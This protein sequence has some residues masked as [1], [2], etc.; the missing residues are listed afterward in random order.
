[1]PSFVRS[2]LRDP[3][4]FSRI[5]ASLFAIVLSVGLFLPT[6]RAQDDANAA[7]ADKDSAAVAMYADAANFQTNG[8]I[9]LAI[10]TWQKFLK[11]FPESPLASKASHYLGVCYMQRDTPDLKAAAD[12][13]AVALKDKKYELREES[14]S[15]RG[16]CLYAATGSDDAADEKLLREAVDTYN[17]L[18]REFPDSRLLDRAYFYRG[19][20]QYSLGDLDAAVKSYDAMLQLDD[21]GDSPLRCD[22]LYAR[23]VAL[24]ELERFDQAQS[25]Y[26]QL[27]DACAGSELI[28]DV[29]IRMGDMDLLQGKLDSAIKQFAAVTSNTSATEDDRAYSFFR[30]G[31]AHAQNGS[32]G[33]ASKSYEALLSEYP[34]SPYA[35]AATLA[36]AQTL[37]QAGDLD[38][39]AKRFRDVLEGSDPEAA[40]ESAHWLARIELGKA[41]RD[42]AQA[43]EPAKTALKVASSRIE[44]GPQGKFAVALKLDAAEALSLLPERLDEAFERYRQ[45]SQEHADHPLAPRALYNAAFVALKL[46]KANDAIQL[47]NEFE[48]KHAND[49]LAPDASFVGAEALLA[50]SKPAEA[51]AQYQELINNTQHRNHPERSTWILRAATAWK[52]ADQPEKTISLVRENLDGLKS[53]DQKAEALMLAGQSELVLGKADEAAATFQQSREV[54]PEWSRSDEA[55]LM[56]GQSQLKA[57]KRDAAEG[58]WKELVRTAPETRAADQARYKLGQL[59]SGDKN[60]AQAIEYFQPVLDAKRDTALLPFARYAMGMAQLQ[61]QQY[62]SAAASLTDVI[63][64]SPDHSLMD[65]ALLARGIAR[66][67]LNE[68]AAARAD[69]QAYLNTEP[70]GNNLG[71]ALYELALLDQNASQT[72]TAAETLQRIVTEVPNYPDMDKVLYELGWSLRESGQEDQALQ[73][74]EE[75]IQRFPENELVADAAYFVGQN[76]YQNERWSEAAKAFQIAADKSNDLDAKEKSLYRL[77]WCFYKQGQY[78]DAEAAFK[79][80]YVEVQQG[81]LLLDSMMMIGESRFKQENFETA[82]RAYSKAREKIQADDDSAKTLRDAAERQ[83]R[84]LILLHGGQSAAQLSQFEDAIGWYDELRERF[85]ATAY[86]PQVFY[87]LGYAAQNVGDD[88]KALNFYSQVAD[89]YRN[90]IAARARFMMGEIHFA[91]KAFDKA[92]PEFQRVMFGFGAD[93]ADPVIKNWQAKS[94]F[95]AGRC[96]E[97]LMQSAQTSTAKAKAAQFAKDFYQYVIDQHPGHELAAKAKQRAEALKAS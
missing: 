4:G 27:L 86:L 34:E 94:G 46:G 5:V 74:F 38:A 32:P 87:E 84:E 6:V 64:E 12:A 23:G 95:E 19:E 59:A 92:I 10:D 29:Q 2:L 63:T 39:A 69:L 44:K 78:A 82:L 21:V 41:N 75:L 67:N 56:A 73:R 7:T 18:T 85:P 62:D 93:K 24:E 45:I 40:T 71:H 52:A 57:G 26:Q 65:D 20:S 53:P 48:Q 91:Q 66:R 1:M 8:A 79:R 89:N 30:Q 58:I 33:D 96:A 90:E 13:F 22:A 25:S 11:Q 35:A 83:V 80:Q 14:L 15:N 76:H 72:Q 88:E 97:L 47:A 55:F 31:F 3:S 50:N 17:M 70:T 36:S 16:W 42:P 61:S 81:K 9:D 54:S 43:T 68:D 77:G 49:P 28:V 51:A 37:Y 60:F